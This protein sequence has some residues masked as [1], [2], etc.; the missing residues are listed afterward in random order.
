MSPTSS[1]S[2]SPLHPCQTLKNRWLQQYSHD[3]ADPGILVLLA[4]GTISSTCGQIASYPL[5][6]VRT[7]MQAQGEAWA[8]GWGREGLTVWVPPPLPSSSS[9]V[10][11]IP[12][13]ILLLDLDDFDQVPPSL[14]GSVYPFVTLEWEPLALTRRSDAG[15][16]LA[17]IAGRL[18]G[19][20]QLPCQA[21]NLRSNLQGWVSEGK[22]RNQVKEGQCRAGYHFV[23]FLCI[24]FSRVLS[25]PLPYYTRIYLRNFLGSFSVCVL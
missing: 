16:A 19:R 10:G 14:C 23:V 20:L 6:L 2:Y 9:W 11:G 12:G 21:G 5:A 18:L 8:G 1:P 17:I 4:C 7:R 25:L 22:A 13:R 3:S 24:F 15:R